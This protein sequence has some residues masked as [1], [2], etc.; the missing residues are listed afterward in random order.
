MI[1]GLG[2]IV[3]DSCRAGSCQT[4]RRKVSLSSPQGVVFGCA[5]CTFAES[6]MR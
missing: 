2:V 5:R 1:Q 3:E 4:T 6:G